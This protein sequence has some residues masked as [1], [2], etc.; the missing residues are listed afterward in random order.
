MTRVLVVHHDRDV[1][2]IE[3]DELRRAGYEVDQCAGPIGGDA[4]PVLRG[5]RCWQ[6]DLADVLVYDVW[7]SGDGAS[8]LIDDLR[9]LHPDK[10]VVLTSPGIMLNWVEIE[11]R[12]RVTPVPW[13]ATGG[14]LADAIEY[15]LQTGADRPLSDQT[16][17]PASKP[18]RPQPTLGPHW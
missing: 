9:D 3:G 15:A 13:A 4:C 12:H 1:A 5:E 10:P 2:D 6:V 18:P 14:G 8:E 11:G 7:A 17:R 16:R